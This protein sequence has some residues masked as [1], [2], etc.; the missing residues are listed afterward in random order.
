M[1]YETEN[2]YGE[3]WPVEDTNETRGY[4]E[5]KVWGDE[6]GGSLWFE[7][8][9]LVDYDGCADLPDQVWDKLEEL[10]YEVYVM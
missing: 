5:H 2:F 3:L 1:K 10:G 4:F 6:Y 9:K 7:D 8:K